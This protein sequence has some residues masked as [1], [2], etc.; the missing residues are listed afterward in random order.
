MQEAVRFRLAPRTIE[1]VGFGE[2]GGVGYGRRGRSGYD[3]E[4]RIGGNEEGEHGEGLLLGEVTE[5][6]GKETLA[7]AGVEE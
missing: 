4:L 1:P 2:E 3:V 6:T 5:E 7:L